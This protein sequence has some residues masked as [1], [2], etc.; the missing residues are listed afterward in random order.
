MRVGDLRTILSEYRPSLALVVSHHGMQVD[1][2]AVATMLSG[3][4]NRPDDDIITLYGC[5][6]IIIRER[7]RG[8]N[9]R[10]RA[11][12]DLFEDAK[13]RSGPSEWLELEA[14]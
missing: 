7:V 6:R 3:L 1:G 8:F 13:E 10:W 2:G 14:R 5:D 11:E 9:G 12:A 4:M